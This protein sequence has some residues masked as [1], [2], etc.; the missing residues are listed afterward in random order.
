MIPIRKLDEELFQIVGLVER[1]TTIFE[2][3]AAYFISVL[4]KN[5]GNRTHTSIELKIPI[6]TVRNRI[7]ELIALGYE[8]PEPPTGRLEQTK[9]MKYREGFIRKRK[10]KKTEF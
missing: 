8:I 1:G 10:T 9:A 7:W 4:H 3:V 2:L 6:R 5:N